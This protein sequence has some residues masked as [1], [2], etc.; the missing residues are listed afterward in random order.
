M[1]IMQQLIRICAI[2][3]KA[4]ALGVSLFALCREADVSYPTVRRWLRGEF[5]PKLLAYDGT[6]QRLEA[7]IEARL[8]RAQSIL[9]PAGVHL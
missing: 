4:A 6:C 2:R 5:Q 8:H 1:R 3:D 9:V 7:A